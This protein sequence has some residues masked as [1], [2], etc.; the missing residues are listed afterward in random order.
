MENIRMP[1][2]ERY[3]P[4]NQQ[5]YYEE[6]PVNN[7]YYAPLPAQANQTRVQHKLP[8]KVRFT[9]RQSGNSQAH[10]SQYRQVDFPTF[11]N[12]LSSRHKECHL[13]EETYP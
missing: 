8:L 9:F 3:R 5:I 12:R 6:R 4:Y 10:N 1:H 2:N 11:L 13:C 7:N